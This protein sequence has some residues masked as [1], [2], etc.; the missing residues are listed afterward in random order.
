MFFDP[1]KVERKPMTEVVPEGVY[2]AQV[3]NVSVKQNDAATMGVMV[4]YNILTPVLHNGKTVMDYFN[5]AHSNPDAERIGKQKFAFLL[6]ALGMG[7][8]PLKNEQLILGKVVKMSVEVK[9]HYKQNGEKQNRVMK[10]TSLNAVDENAIKGLVKS[11]L[12]DDV[13][14]DPA[15]DGVPVEEDTPF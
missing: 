11:N 2:V 9:D 12:E 10:Y 4:F 8:K 13:Q 1:T 14:F 6:D 3:E 7:D 15:V 5:V